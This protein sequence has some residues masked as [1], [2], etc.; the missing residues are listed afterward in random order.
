MTHFS[1]RLINMAESETLAM[2]RL[3]RELKA[4]GKDIINLSLGEPDF[5]TPDYIK[6]AAK[7]AI[8]QNFSHYTPVAGYDELLDAICLKLKRDNNLDFKRSNIMVSTG[9]KQCIANLVMACVDD[10]DEVIVPAPYWV[11]YR[12]IIKMAGG[13]PVEVL[14]GIDKDFKVTADQVEKAITSKTKMLMFSSPCNPTGSVYSHSELGS[15]VNVLAKHPDIVIVSDEIY[16]LINFVGGHVSIGTFDAVKNRTVTI[17]GLSK[18]FAMTGWRLGY[19]A[20]PEEIA[21]ASIKMQGQFTSA[22]CS[23]TQRAAIVALTNGP[24][25]VSGMVD[26][27]KKRKELAHRLLSQIPDIIVNNPQGAFYFFPEVSKY[28]GKSFGTYTINNSDDLS[29]YLIHEANVSTVPGS[30]FGAENYI[31]LSYATSEDLIEKAI[32]RIKVAL[33]NL[34]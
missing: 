29:M 22:T 6:Q 34:K 30:A 28:M 20:A 31:R 21:K 3:S 18:A 2:A 24:E 13:I 8:D 11:S 5:N 12:E 10:G 7:D 23:I 15:I 32:E 9:A 17:N 27:F 1:R 14:A 25:K 4:Q 19:M 26:A 33:L 16:E